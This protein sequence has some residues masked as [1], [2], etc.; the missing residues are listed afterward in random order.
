MSCG[1]VLCFLCSIVPVGV[2]LRFRRGVGL[3][4]GSLFVM[5][6]IGRLPGWEV[7]LIALFLLG[8]ISFVCLVGMAM[9]VVCA[10]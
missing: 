8:L 10:A 6:G 9:A 7:L 3:P 2:R 4:G 1:Y 5:V